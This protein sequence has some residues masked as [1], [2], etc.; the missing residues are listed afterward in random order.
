MRSH[1]AISGSFS[2][3][4]AGEEVYLYSGDAAGDLTGYSYGFKF[5]GAPPDV[6]FGRFVTS[7]GLEHYPLQSKHTLGASNSGPKVGPVV[8]MTS[9]T[10]NCTVKYGPVFTNSAT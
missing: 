1:D 6:S 9:G 4:S 5:A 7:D 3:S 10:G 8:T 2:L